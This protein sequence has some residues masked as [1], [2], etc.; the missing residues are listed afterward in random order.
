MDVKLDVPIEMGNDFQNAI[1]TLNWEFKVEELEVE[2]TDP[3]PPRTGG[4]ANIGLYIGLCAASAGMLI[5]LL[6]AAKKKKAK[7]E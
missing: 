2:P 5:F 3:Q 4:S 1:G 6:L 7:E